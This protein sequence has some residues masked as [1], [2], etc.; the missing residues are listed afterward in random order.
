LYY[1]KNKEAKMPRPDDC[2]PQIIKALEKAGWKLIAHPYTIASGVEG[3]YVYADLR[4][5]DTAIQLTLA[6]IPVRLIVV[7]I[8]TEE[9]LQWMS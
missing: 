4:L 8:E 2:E 1:N 5:V 3:R 6:K 7:N 9:V